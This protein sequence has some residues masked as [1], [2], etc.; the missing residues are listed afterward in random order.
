MKTASQMAIVD[1]QGAK[2]LTYYDGL[3]A[4]V[5]IRPVCE[6]LGIDWARQFTKIKADP[7]LSASVG[8]RP[9]VG[10]HGVREMVTLPI[11]MLQGWLFKI[12]PD[13]VKPEARETVLTYQRECYQV[14]HDYWTKGAAINPRMAHALPSATS[15]IIKLIEVVKREG[16]VA[17]RAT[18]H[19]LLDQMCTARGIETP[20]LEQLM[21][22][23]L[24]P[25]MAAKLDQFWSIVFDIEAQGV[26]LNW[27]RDKSLFAIHYP[28]LKQVFLEQGVDFT[29]DNRFR[30]LLK[31]SR[32]PAFEGE[33]DVN[34][35]DGKGRHSLIFRKTDP[36]VL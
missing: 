19:Q 33:G 21:L 12:N 35:F 20:P 10:E 27:H 32:C 5:A 25:R 7:V 31:L 30:G 2:L 29:L 1:F 9:T 4:H 22:G 34:G 18:L 11:G 23:D 24:D 28:S 3:Q 13:R 36:E 26:V 17:A 6:A 8:L 16:N 14:L 15:D